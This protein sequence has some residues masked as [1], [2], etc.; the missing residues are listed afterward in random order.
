MGGV[1]EVLDVSRE[2]LYIRLQPI[3]R[4]TVSFFVTFVGVARTGG[5]GDQRTANEPALRQGSSS[6]RPSLD[7]GRPPPRTR[8][9]V[10]FLGT[11]GHYVETP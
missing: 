4:F 2:S 11:A 8:L 5:V 6:S 7:C 3:H 9:A 1:S 10:R